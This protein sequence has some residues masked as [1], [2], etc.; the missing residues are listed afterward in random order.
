MKK[1]VFNRNIRDAAV[2][3]ETR[4]YPSNHNGLGGSLGKN[5]QCEYTGDAIAGYALLHKQGYTPVLRGETLKT[6]PKKQ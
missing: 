2:R 6:D 5:T 3:R 1:S 4:Q